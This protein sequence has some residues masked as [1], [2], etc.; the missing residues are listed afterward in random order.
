MVGRRL[1]TLLLNHP[2]IKFNQVSGVTGRLAIVRCDLGGER[3]R[4]QGSLRGVVAPLSLPRATAQPDG[5]LFRRSPSL[6]MSFGVVVD[7]R[8]ERANGRLLG[9]RRKSRIS[10]SPHRRFDPV[11]S[12]M[13]REVNGSTFF[14]GSSSLMYPN[15]VTSG[16]TLVW[17]PLC[18]STVYERS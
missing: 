4:A 7:P 5:R 10:N 17:A 3:D 13:V 1:S 14:Q 11:A 18:G 8:A 9:E 16:L 6:R 15:C 12:L 2:V